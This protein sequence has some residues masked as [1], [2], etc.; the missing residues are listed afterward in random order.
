MAVFMV[1]EDSLRQAWFD[2]DRPQLRAR[3]PKI[4]EF[5]AS[6]RAINIHLEP[7]KRIR[8]LGGC[9]PVNWAVVRTPEELAVYPFKNNWAAHVITEHFAVKYK[10]VGSD[11][12]RG[13]EAFQANLD[14]YS[15]EGWELAGT[16]G[17]I[18]IFKK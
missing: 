5:Y 2:T 10:A 18:L 14:K 3:L 11:L 15:A 17:A 16:S 12:G 1:P 6:V 4:P 9:E 7:A 8:V 13:L